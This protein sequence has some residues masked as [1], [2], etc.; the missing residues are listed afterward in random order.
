MEF[1]KYSDEY[2]SAPKCIDL[3]CGA[4]GLSLGFTQAGGIPIAALDSDKDSI[5]T[6][7]KMFGI[8]KD[9]QCVKIEEWK[10]KEQISD[11]DVI[12]G[13]PPCQG[14][15]IARGTRFVDDPRNS[16]YKHFVKAVDK[17]KPKWIVMENV[18]G[19]ISIGNGI[20]LQQIYQ[21]FNEIGYDL[22]HKVINMAEYGVPQTRKRTIFV[23]NRLGKEFEWP[24]PRYKALRNNDTIWTEENFRT[25]DMAIGD[26][27]WPKGKY[28][29]HRANSQMRGPRNRDIHIQPAFTLRVRGDE[30]AICEEP[31]VGAFPPGLCPE[32]D[33]HYRPCQNDL[34]KTL[35]EAPPEWI[36]GYKMPPIKDISTDNLVGTRRLDLREQA[37]LQTFPDW[38]K[39]CGSKAAQGRQIG[40]AVPPLFARQLFI[41]II[42]QL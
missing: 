18:P 34:Q 9:V 13:G 33:L 6:Y 4:G 39:F 12:I 3:F 21:D 26:L 42:E 7:S 38:F 29:A 32:M 37:R 40:N 17:L 14:F 1:S 24:K 8:C 16:L 19:I 28:F 20:V 22:T 41:K 30:F 25:V 36:N 31:A 35:R 15:S 2:A 23:G 10:L 11:V 5:E 27:P